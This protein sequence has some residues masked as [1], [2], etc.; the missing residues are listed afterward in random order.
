MAAIAA[1]LIVSFVTNN[2]LTQS[3]I[4]PVDTDTASTARSYAS[5]STAPPHWP[6]I[7]GFALVVV[8]QGQAPGDCSLP[9]GTTITG[10]APGSGAV[11]L[12]SASFG[13]TRTTQVNVLSCAG[14]LFGPTAV[15][16]AQLGFA[17]QNVAVGVVTVNASGGAVLSAVNATAHPGQR[18]SSLTWSLS[19]LI[20]VRP[21]RRR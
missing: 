20:E 1:S 13:A 7:P 2:T 18:L 21:G 14:C 4:L 17:C 3:S 5:Q 9:P 19:P 10:L 15:F 8:G 6:P 11:A 16:S 12:T